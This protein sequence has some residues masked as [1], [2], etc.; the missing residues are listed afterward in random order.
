[1]K[2]QLLFLIAL[3]FFVFNANAQTI[4]IIG[5]TSPSA[6][7]GIDIDMTTTDNITYTLNN[8]TLTTATDPGTTGLKFRQDHDW[9][10]N[11]GNA[12]FPSGTGV[13]NG[14]NI[15][16]VAG[17]YDITFNRSNGTYTFIQS[18][19]VPHNIGIWGPAVDSQNGFGGADINM[20]TS[21]NITYTLSGFYFSSGTAYFRENDATTNVWG[22][23]AFPSGTAVLSGPSIP[24][25]GGEW[26]V[27]FNRITGAYSFAYPSVGIL[28][29]ATPNGWGTDIDLSTTDGFNYS[30]SDLMLSDGVVKF[31]KDNLWDINWGAL[32]FPTGT[33][34]QNGAEIPVIA[35]TYN[36]TFEKTS[37]NYNFSS[38]LSKAQNSISNVKIYPNPTNNVWNLSHAI[39]ID[40]VEL[41]DATGKMIQSYNPNVNQFELDGSSLSNG[42]YFVK[43]KSGLDFAVQK[44]IKN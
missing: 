33:G 6:S 34:V 26:F 44:I 27:T 31:R 38:T 37:G 35:G 19:S 15:M 3:T 5:S 9:A 11:W 43:I 39:T 14:A 4:S 10:I 25:T 16:T 30:I 20:S 2:K 17:T 22:A 13:Q 40:S 41:M 1:M 7:W 28:G 42:V 8:V 32:E 36:V 23:V 29:T 12:N 24:V 18:S 21:D